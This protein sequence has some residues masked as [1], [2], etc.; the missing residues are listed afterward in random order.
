MGGCT[1]LCCN[2]P[3]THR[4]QNIGGIGLSRGKLA[5]LV[6]W[7][8]TFFGDRK[9]KVRTMG[10]ENIASL[11]GSPALNQLVDKVFSWRTSFTILI[12]HLF[13][14]SISFLPE[15]RIQRRRKC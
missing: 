14:L 2:N 4:S 11:I 5:G 3:N 7:I 1:L 6:T 9:N 13:L 10:D 15:N 12:R 8:Q